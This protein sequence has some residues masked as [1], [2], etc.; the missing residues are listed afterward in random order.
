M[1]ESRRDALRRRRVS[2]LWRVLVMGGALMGLACNT[3]G[4]SKDGRESSSSSKG[5]SGGAA[6]AGGAQSW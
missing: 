5:R 3:P 1:S 2:K 6:E 4:K